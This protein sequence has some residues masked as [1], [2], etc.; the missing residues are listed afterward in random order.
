MRITGTEPSS[1]ILSQKRGSFKNWK[2]MSKKCQKQAESKL[3]AMGAVKSLSIREEKFK[4]HQIA[5]LRP[6]YLGKGK[7]YFL[8]INPES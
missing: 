1:V 2:V 7:D 4:L 3:G 6:L 5:P 8:K